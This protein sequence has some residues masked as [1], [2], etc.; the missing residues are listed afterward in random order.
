[1]SNYGFLFPKQEYT[2]GTEI[3]TRIKYGTR[4]NYSIPRNSKLKNIRTFLCTCGCK[5]S[6]FSSDF[7]NGTVERCPMCKTENITI[8]D[9][10][11]KTKMFN[12][13]YQ[14]VEKD[15][16][17]FKITVQRNKAIFKGES[18]VEVKNIGEDAIEFKNNRIKG[19]DYRGVEY[20]NNRHNGIKFR[21]F[22][23]NRDINSKKILKVLSNGNSELY[24]Y[25]NFLY[26]N[27]SVLPNSYGEKCL[28]HCLKRD[29][30]YPM[31]ERLYNAGFKHVLITNLFKKS[32]YY[33]ELNC[34]HLDLEAK[35]LH[36]VFKIQKV[37]LKFLKQQDSASSY[38]L[39]VLNDFLKKA[40]GNKF[41]IMLEIM[42]QETLFEQYDQ[43]TFLSYFTNLYELGYNNVEALTKYL[44]RRTKLEQGFEN[45]T[46]SAR[47]L[48]DYI[49]MQKDLGFEYEKYPSSLKKVH[50]IAVMNTNILK[51][52]IE[53]K[54]FN[55]AI[56]KE[57]YK[58]LEL[59]MKNFS[60]VMPKSPDDLLKE[61]ESL[62]H[63]V[64]SYVKDVANG[65]CK[66]LFLRENEHLDKSYMTIEV[67]GDSVIQ[68]KGTSNRRGKESDL[69]LLKEWAKK[70]NLSVGNTSSL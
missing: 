22:Q 36:Q 65:L 64:A 1:M 37:A 13:N 3:F 27:F 31:I 20:T 66:I 9:Q 4:K 42:E 26:T 17:D 69:E 16:K 41:N 61:G 68:F 18:K 25:Y 38:Q 28:E 32:G 51:K 7:T 21:A 15:G 45:P 50:D 19:T 2:E 12:G 67:R 55:E 57:D 62:S 52:E 58:G 56:E 48:V 39:H 24:D 33:G 14:L 34:K 47:Y 63:C 54:K 11:F 10:Y 70:K 60:V 35:K 53:T 49:K 44:C 23:S 40:D 59:K 6:V 8:F 43:Y 29:A 46:E 5:V 30:L